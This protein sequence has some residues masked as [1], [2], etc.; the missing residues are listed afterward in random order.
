MRVG[1]E[2]IP[3]ARKHRRKLFVWPPPMLAWVG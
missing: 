2:V 3:F 1:S